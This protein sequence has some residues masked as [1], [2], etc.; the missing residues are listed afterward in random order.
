[1]PMS[2]KADYINPFLVSTVH[3]FHE[4]LALELVREQA[5]IRQ[6]FASQH[7]VT[8]LIGLIGKTTGTVAVSLP[9]DIALAVAEKLLGERR[10]EIDAHRTPIFSNRI[11]FFRG[12]LPC[13][14]VPL[15]RL[16]SLNC[17]W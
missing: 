8:G 15:P 13:H 9:R 17:S 7:E 2:M 16:R 3:V 1:M 14:A 5:F 4:M 11:G 12:D 6:D 10:A